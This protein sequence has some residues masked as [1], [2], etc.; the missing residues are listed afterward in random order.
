VYHEA[1]RT[2]NPDLK[3][4]NKDPAFADIA[5]NKKTQ[6][7]Y[8]A[9]VQTIFNQH[10]A[11]ASLKITAKDF[12]GKTG[13]RAVVWQHDPLTDTYKPTEHRGVMEH[14]NSD[15]PSFKLIR[16]SEGFIISIEMIDD[17]L[18]QS[19]PVNE[20]LEHH[21]VKGMKWG[22]TKSGDTSSTSTKTSHLRRSAKEVTVTQKPGR[23]VR[24]SGGQRQTA[25][26][27]AIKVAAARQVAK[28]STTDSLTNKQ[29]AD[30]VSRMNLEKQF[31]K[32]SKEADR[33]D[34]SRRAIDKVLGNKKGQQV[35]KSVG[36][37][38]FKTAV[39][40]AAAA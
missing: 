37:I 3:T 33:R 4:L 29:M 24:T 34:R 40:A 30:A 27:D 31:S 39:K 25:S 13:L 35:A 7:Q 10:L 11:Q 22:V 23:F 1:I 38:A 12:G 32:L 28:K 8:I 14:A 20:F 15:F 26:S 16:D 19:D 5:T 17:S 9:V 18:T 21:G 36:S 2:L 6:R